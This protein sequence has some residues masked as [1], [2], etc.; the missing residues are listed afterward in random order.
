MFLW[1]SIYIVTLS[2]FIATGNIPEK[3]KFFMVWKNIFEFFSA[4]FF[5][6]EFVIMC[7]VILCV[8][9]DENYDKVNLA[10]EE[11]ED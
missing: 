11:E 4:I 2:A 5:L 10:E 3:E 8:K 9:Y 1:C 6:L 7:T